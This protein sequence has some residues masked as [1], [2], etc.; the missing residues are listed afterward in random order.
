M[1][2]FHSSAAPQFPQLAVKTYAAHRVWTGSTTSE[3]KFSPV[4][5][6]DAAKI[7]H[8]ARRLERQT[9]ISRRDAF[10]KVSTQGTLGRMGI[11]VLHTLLYD[12]LN[13][14]SGRLDPCRAS[15][16]AK[17]SVS[18]RSVAR[19]LNRLRD[20][21]ILNWVRRCAGRLID[22]RFV[23]EQESNAYGVVPPS[24]WKGWRAEPEAPRPHPDSWGGAP[25][26]AAT[27]PERGPRAALVYMEGGPAKGLALAL[28]RLQSRS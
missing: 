9:A 28:A 17:A 13:Y 1:K 16:A 22:G 15:I 27:A 6:R 7:F 24:C 21:G 20:A 2:A 26:M 14:R 8:A 3:V 19:A 5:K 25:P 23:L 10:G 11:L 12:F 4:S 18:V